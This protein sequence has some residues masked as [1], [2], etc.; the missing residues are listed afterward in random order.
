MRCFC[1]C[2]PI[3][4]FLTVLAAVLTW[5]AMRLARIRMTSRPAEPNP[6]RGHRPA[7]VDM[8]QPP[9]GRRPRR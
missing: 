9:V 5:L 7:A 1:C 6:D 2:L 8:R 4:F 3:P